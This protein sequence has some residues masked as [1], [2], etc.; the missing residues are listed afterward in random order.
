VTVEQLFGALLFGLPMAPEMVD[1]RFPWFLQQAGGL[2]LT[3]LIT[4]FSLIIGA[5]IGTI[6]ALGR[7]ETATPARR[8]G[9]ERLAF[10]ARVY[11][12]AG[13]V[14]GIRGLPIMLLVLLVFY[15]PYRV[16]DLRVPGFVL[17]TMAFSIYTGAYFSEILR[18]GFRSVHPELSQAGRL[19]GLT[20]RQV[21]MKIELPI[22]CRTMMP[23]LINLAVTVFKDTSTLAIVAV[24]ELT[25]VARQMLTSEPIRYELAL[26][27]VLMLYWLPA[28]VLSTVAFRSERGKAILTAYPRARVKPSSLPVNAN[29]L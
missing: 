20:P 22:V 8:S 5:V 28:T 19:L 13:L 23:D 24:P 15:L 17:A 21:L 4:L 10:R 6:L 14:E 29:R 27:I 2:L 3:L 11:T 7:R 16:A 12:A 1:P 25:Y 26:L 18:A 9:L